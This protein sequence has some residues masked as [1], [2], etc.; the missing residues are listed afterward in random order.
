MVLRSV[1][2][3]ERDRDK[4][5][6]RKLIRTLFIYLFNNAILSAVTTTWDAFRKDDDETPYGERWLETYGKEFVDNVNPV[7]MIPFVKDVVDVI[8]SKMT[9]EYYGATDMT[10]D[11]ISKAAL[12]IRHLAQRLKPDKFG[13]TTKSDYGISKEIVQALSILSGVPAYNVLN[14]I[15]G[16]HNGFF[17]NWETK[18][19]S[20]YQ[21]LYKSIDEGKD[22]TE[23]V[24]KLKD[25]GK[26]TSA[27]RT[28]L[29]RHYK[30]IYLEITDMTEKANMKNTLIKAYMADGYSRDEAIK[31]IDGWK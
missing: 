22:L 5:A 4:K 31:I 27:I 25:A 24:N 14:D 28:Q 26:D 7:N 9:G 23:A 13:K 2:G 29:T 6:Y 1:V 19:P 21:S 15:E 3:A 12:G 17:K 20:E 10:Y 18:A 30:P 16:I 8:S 11:G